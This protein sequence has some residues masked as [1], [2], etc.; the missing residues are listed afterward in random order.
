[1]SIFKKIKDF[2]IFLLLI[3][4]LIFSVFYFIY[5]FGQKKLDIIKELPVMIPLL[6]GCIVALTATKTQDY[7]ETT[8]SE[9]LNVETRFA[10]N[11]EMFAPST[12]TWEIGRIKL[13][14]Y[15]SRNLSHIRWIFICTVAVLIGGFII[16][17]YG[18]YG[19][20]TRKLL[21]DT[22]ILT[23]ATGLLIEFIGAS[24][25]FVYK[26]TIKQAKDYVTILERMNAI[27]MSVQIIESMDNDDKMLKNE[28]K[29]DLAKRLLE[30]YSQKS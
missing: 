12:L 23:T 20:F 9:L 27:S 22:T 5:I 13:Q 11:P 7:L 15:L 16:I 3:S 30:F 2:N 26:S 8:R 14:D 19:I 18:I 17:S 1:M 4:L 6:I 21:L 28:A 25:F 24:F 10:A 29:A